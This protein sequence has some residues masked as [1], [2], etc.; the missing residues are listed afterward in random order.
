MFAR[1]GGA[2]AGSGGSNFQFPGGGAGGFQFPGGGAGGFQFPGGFGG[3]GG[4]PG[5]GGHKPPEDLFPK[6]GSVAKLGKPKFPNKVSNPR[7]T[8]RIFCRRRCCSCS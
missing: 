6:G 5:G 7:L 2:R 4:F 3:S 8:M 1:S